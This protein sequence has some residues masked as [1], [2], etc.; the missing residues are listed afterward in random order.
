MMGKDIFEDI[1]I[2]ALQFDMEMEDAA[3]QLV[4]NYGKELTE[5][6]LI[7]LIVLTDG[8]TTE[9]ILAQYCLDYYLTQN[10]QPERIDTN[11]F[12]STA[13]KAWWKLW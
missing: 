8:A 4:D 7:L 1:N 13:K 3:R 5:S 12:P 2:D 10:Y 6:D 11:K 9:S